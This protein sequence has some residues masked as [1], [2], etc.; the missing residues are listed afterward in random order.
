MS[1]W[2]TNDDPGSGPAIIVEDNK[3]RPFFRFMKSD[4]EVAHLNKYGELIST[5]GYGTKVVHLGIGDV[6]ADSDSISYPV[7][8]SNV[9]VTIEEIEY[10]VDTTL[11]ADGTNYQTLA[12][13]DDAGNN[14][15]STAGTTAAGIANGTWTAGGTTLSSTHAKLNAGESLK[16]VFTKAYK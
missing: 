8:V 4:T 12:F 6:A 15:Y 7:F 16:L 3:G 14:L 2:N 11:G 5:S 10:T 1:V 9:P 13:T